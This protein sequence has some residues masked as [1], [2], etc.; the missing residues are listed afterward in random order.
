MIALLA[1]TRAHCY[2]FV[3]IKGKLH[4]REI[5]SAFA[6]TKRKKVSVLCAYYLE[7][8]LAVGSRGPLYL[9]YS[10][11]ENLTIFISFLARLTDKRNNP[12]G[13]T[14]SVLKY[15]RCP[16]LHFFLF[17]NYIQWTIEQSSV[18]WHSLRAHGDT[19]YKLGH[20]SVRDRTPHSKCQHLMSNLL[21]RAGLWNLTHFK[22][23]EDA[24]K[25][26][27]QSHTEGLMLKN[28]FSSPTCLQCMLDCAPLQAFLRQLPQPGETHQASPQ[29]H[30]QTPSCSL[31]STNPRAILAPGSALQ[32]PEVFALFSFLWFSALSLSCWISPHPYLA[33]HPLPFHYSASFLSPSYFSSHLQLTWFAFHCS[34]HLHFLSHS[35]LY[36]NLHCPLLMFVLPLSAASS[37]STCKLLVIES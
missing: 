2:A 14:I 18:S 23:E 36:T 8:T 3:N 24:E 11:S 6:R 22:A 28:N 20:L 35:H 9:M 34:L 4:C 21:S 27:T 15:S 5:S 19:G 1:I 37:T 12:W 29:P 13:R 16:S 31:P 17:W 7:I 26:D 30:S 25:G 33:H 32:S 10:L